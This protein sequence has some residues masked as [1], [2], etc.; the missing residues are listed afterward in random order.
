MLEELAQSMRARLE[1]VLREEPGLAGRLEAAAAAACRAVSLLP[2]EME[3]W[4]SAVLSLVPAGVYLLCAG[5][6]PQA[7][8]S[9]RLAVEAM[10]QLHYFVW[11]ASRRGAELGDLLSQWS[12]RGRAFTLKMLRSVPGIPGVYRRQLARTYLELAH[13]THPSAEALKLATSSPGPG[14]L[15]DLVV[16][17]LDFIAYLALHHA[18]LREAGQLLDALAE[19]GLE[20]SQRY[21]AKRLGA[22]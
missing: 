5:L 1:Q 10:V 2:G 14:V 20:R 12:R 19:A 15:G 9:L 6:I 21:L 13:L 8:F 11:Q 7:G 18:P 16:R 4:R 22:R 3:P 17:A